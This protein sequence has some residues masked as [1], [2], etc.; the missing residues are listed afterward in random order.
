MKCCSMVCSA[1]Q[2]RQHASK[3]AEAAA[4]AEV[5]APAAAAHSQV[6]QIWGK[7]RLAPG[8]WNGPLQAGVAQLSVAPGKQATQFA[9][10]HALLHRDTW[11]GGKQASR[12][13]G[14]SAGRQGEGPQVLQLRPLKVGGQGA[15]ELGIVSQ[16]QGAQ[17]AQRAWAHPD[18]GEGGA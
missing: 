16:I 9:A 5:A 13:A 12:Q 8:L 15:G 11:L 1:G 3:T 6:P 2:Q 10:C 7:G 17:R 4:A 18:G 14:S